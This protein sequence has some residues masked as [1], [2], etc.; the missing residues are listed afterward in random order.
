[1]YGNEKKQSELRYVCIS[2]E[3]NNKMAAMRF[4]G[5]FAKL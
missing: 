4:L 1:M 2:V 3:R 5:A